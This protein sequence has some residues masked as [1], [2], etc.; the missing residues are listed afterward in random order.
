MASGAALAG[1]ARSDIM[2]AMRD[3]CATIL[4]ALLLTAVSPARD[5]WAAPEDDVAAA[6][7]HY[8]KGTRAF[9][10]GAYDEAIAEYSA[11]YRLKDAPEILYN[12]AQAHRLAGH[13]GDA[14]RL[15][16]QYLVKVPNASNREQVQVKIDEL[17][18]LID[19]QNKTKTGLPPDQPIQE[20]VKPQPAGRS[21]AAVEVT[22]APPP[23]EK[24]L[25]KKAWFWGVVAGAAVVV[26]G[27]IALGV[28]FG[29]SQHDP[30][31]TLGTLRVNN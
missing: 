22:T 3:V 29:S 26:G 7:E 2:V 24:P 23:R 8:Q 12:M 14:L 13:P 17:Q 25:V 18:K 31:A 21:G 9:E 27:S 11:A 1:Q 30:S 28:V 16:R 20:E 6:R 19:Q 10:L 15:Y 4:G 5:C